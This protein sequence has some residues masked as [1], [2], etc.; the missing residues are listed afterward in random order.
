M[1]ERATLLP[2]VYVSDM[3]RS[4]AF[5]RALGCEGEL[6]LAGGEAPVWLPLRLGGAPL[7]LHTLDEVPAGGQVSLA[8]NV[9]DL[10]RYADG[11][12]AAGIEL[13]RPIQEEP[14]GRSLVIQDPD[15]LLIQVNEH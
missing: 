7:A 12:K 14:F 5:Y 2:I 4:F 15:G 8:L 10:D 13:A 11:L 9:G 3:Q 6:R 1:N